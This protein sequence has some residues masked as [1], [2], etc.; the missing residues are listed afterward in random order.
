MTIFA[1]E[2]AVFLAP[3]SS[4]LTVRAS[5]IDFSSTP[6]YSGHCTYTHSMIVR[7]HGLVYTSGTATRIRRGWKR[8][9]RIEEHHEAAQTWLADGENSA[10]RNSRQSAAQLCSVSHEARIVRRPSPLVWYIRAAYRNLS[11]SSMGYA[12]VL[13]DEYPRLPDASLRAWA[14]LC[15]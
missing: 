7:C 6:L 12:D 10:S 2:E 14:R 8:C 15:M 3:W 9:S 5:R 11:F 13:R 4:H 1:P